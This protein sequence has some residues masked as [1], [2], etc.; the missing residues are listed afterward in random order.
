VQADAVV[1]LPDDALLVLVEVASV[2]VELAL[3]VAAAV[4]VPPLLPEAEQENGS[5][6]VA[7]HRF[8]LAL[9]LGAYGN[10]KFSCV[11]AYLEWCRCSW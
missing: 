4:V 6:P 7:G 8:S 10:R 1:V 3:L 2:V 9:M 11:M 5:G